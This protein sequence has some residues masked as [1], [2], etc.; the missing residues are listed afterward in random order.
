LGDFLAEQLTRRTQSLLF[1]DERIQNTFDLLQMNYRYHPKPAKKYFSLELEVR[2]KSPTPWASQPSALQE[3]VIYLLNL[4]SREFVEVLRSYHFS[5]YEFLKLDLTS[6][7]VS[8]ILGRDELELL[9]QNKAD[10]AG[11][12]G[13]VSPL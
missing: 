7:P 6:D 11:L 12:L 13:G 10:L 5:E 4:A 1:T 9:R 2:L 3:D 8:H